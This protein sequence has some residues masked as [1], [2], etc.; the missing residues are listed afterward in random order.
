MTSANLTKSI[1]DYKSAKLAYDKS[2]SNFLRGRTLEK[3]EKDAAKLVEAA[4]KKA[5]QVVIEATELMGKA[6]CDV[7]D[8]K[9][10][11][12]AAKSLASNA[13]KMMKE[14]VIERKSVN[15]AQASLTLAFESLRELTLEASDIKSM[16]EGKMTKLSDFLASAV[17]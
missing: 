8:S 13:D 12:S 6:K 2:H 11:E 4:Q 9:I 14:L 5:D 15:D 10:I 17:D 3:A 7:A 1:K 16:Y